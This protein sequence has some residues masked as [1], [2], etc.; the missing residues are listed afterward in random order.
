MADK[1]FGVDQL[2]ILGNGTPTISAPN[3]LNLDCHTVAISTSVTVG[4]NLTVNGNIDLGNA[5]SD[6]ISLTGVVDTNIIP[7]ADSSKDIGSNS[8]RFAN[9]YF[10][11][12]YGSGAN[13]TNL[14]T[15]AGIWTVTN[16]SSSNYVI[17]G[18]GG[19]SS[20]N[21]PDLYL[22]RGKTY[23]FAMNASGHGFGIQT[24]SGTWNNSNA[25]TTGITNAG[26]DTGTITFAVPYSAPARLYYA[27]TSS[28]SGMVGNLYIQGAA[29]TVDVSNNAD[30]RVITGG[31]GSSLN[32]EANLTFDGTSL[33]IGNTFSP[34][35]E[36]DNLV[37]GGSGWQGMTIY[38]EGGGGVIQ[39]ADDADNRVGQIL[40]NHSTNE[41]LFRTNGNADRFEIQSN[42][43]VTITNGN[44]IVGTGGK[45]IDFSAQTSTSVTGSSTS[46]ELLDH[47]EEGTFTP[48]LAS[49]TSLTVYRA[50]FIRIGRLCHIE[51][52][53]IVGSNSSGTVLRFERLPFDF[54]PGGDN[55]AGFT[56]AVTNTNRDDT[57][58]GNRGNNWISCA[59]KSNQDVPTSTYSNKQIRIS[60]SYIIS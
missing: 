22:E 59:T 11:T 52:G 57:F 36:G 2:D 60:G 18:P 38:G 31:S 32:A 26:A 56:V 49:G 55:A 20:A 21:N 30:N 14:P 28:H 13:L 1:A 53:V 6:T 33:K 54:N 7:S 48:V 47:Y 16:N 51:L 15:I 5:S 45:G 17:T 46:S 50:D 19:L 23:Q 39:F 12:V 3:Q 44:L 10:D 58:Y 24:S 25:Y 37:I 29:S 8:V 41:M 42:G 9:G 4:A 34:H 40:Y 43:D 35:S 27:C